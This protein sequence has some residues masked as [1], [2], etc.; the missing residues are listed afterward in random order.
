V[1][2]PTP[3]DLA[4][5]HRDW[6]S[7]GVTN[8]N[9]LSLRIVNQSDVTL[10]RIPGGANLTLSSENFRASIT[11]ARVIAQSGP[12][13]PKVY[14]LTALAELGQILPML[15]H[16]GDLLHKLIT[17]PGSLTS[18]RVIASTTLAYQF[19][20]GPLIQD[21]GRLMNFADLVSSRQRE[22]QR[23]YDGEGIRKK[24]FCG[25]SSNTASGQETVVSTGGMLISPA[26][27]LTQQHRAW[28]T[29][30][31]KLRDP[32]QIGKEATW[33]DAWRSTYGFSGGQIPVQIWKAL[34]WSWAIDWF[35]G[36]SDL[37]NAHQNMVLF[38][39]SNVCVMCETNGTLVWKP[40]TSGSN[41]FGGT[42]Y[43][44]Q[45]KR[46]DARSLGSLA[47]SNLRVP[48][49]D[50]FKLSVLGSLAILALL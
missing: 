49:L 5:T 12:N 21:L 50:A 40:Y 36:L 15:K 45:Y 47:A 41:V 18:P 32:S 46:R 35:S 37:L 13:T 26:W 20:W 30:H 14:S 19:G 23:L 6:Q 34:P 2:Y 16:A 3:H 29:V 44:H 39:P 43:T 48:N 27:R 11:T 17:N 1:G 10:G 28:A 4:I 38:K 8:W 31:W 25:T 33:R 9:G 24:L 22:L 7:D 42:T